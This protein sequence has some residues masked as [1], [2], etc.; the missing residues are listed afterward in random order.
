VGMAEVATNVLHDVGNALTSIV[1][2]TGLMRQSI[3]SSR[4]GRLKLVSALLEE[5]RNNLPRFFARDPRGNHLV[6]Y[7]SVL[8]LELTQEQSA[9]Q[10]TLEDMNK[11]VSRVRAIIQM[12]Q[13]YATSTLLPEDCELE[14]LLDDAQRLH[15]GALERAGIQVTREVKPL[16]RVKVDRYKVLQILFNLLSNACHALEAKAPGDR[17]L[18]IRLEPRGGWVRIQVMDSGVGIAPEV[19]PRLFNQ[20]F[21]TREDGQGIG[22]HSSALA[23]QLLG[24]RLTLESEGRDKGATATLEL[25][26]TP[27][28]AALAVAS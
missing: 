1:V 21:T 26:V 8:A 25:P 22:L 14:E 15:Q 2:D 17:R 13:T 3:S 24:G 11:N 23:A 27:P 18:E 16:P 10:G 20:G 6:D 9:L 7:L 28:Q 4:L 5:H 19:K 12:Q